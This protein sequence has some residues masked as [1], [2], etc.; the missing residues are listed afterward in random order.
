MRG[1]LGQQ[2]QRECIRGGPAVLL[3]KAEG[4]EPG[5]RQCLV[6]RCRWLVGPVE[7]GDVGLGALPVEE[8]LKAVQQQLLLVSEGKVHL[9]TPSGF[10]SGFKL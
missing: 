10:W 1:L 5:L 4:A 2:D 8:F 7:L 3:G 9:S 6:E